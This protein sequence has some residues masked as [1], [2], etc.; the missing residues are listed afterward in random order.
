MSKPANWDTLTPEAQEAWREKKRVYERNRTQP[1]KAKTLERQKKSRQENKDKTRAS[2]MKHYEANREKLQAK[3]RERY[4]SDP[5]I[6]EQRRK[7]AAELQKIRY[8]A[9]HEKNLEIKRKWAAENKDKVLRHQENHRH[10]KY[11]AE[12]KAKETELASKPVELDMSK[13]LAFI[14]KKDGPKRITPDMA[15]VREFI[16]YA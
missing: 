10:R 12:I 15:K 13:V 16:K 7:R 11:R 8:H 5:K 4:N 3:N 2:S 1:K 6:I 14:N 9:S